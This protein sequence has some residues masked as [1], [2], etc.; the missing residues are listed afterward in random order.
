MSKLESKW[1]FK[2]ITTALGLATTVLLFQIAQYSI[3]FGNAGTFSQ[4]A[5]FILSTVGL[6][7]VFSFAIWFSALMAAPKLVR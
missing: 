2:T 3:P 4:F 6:Q 5:I 1:W 7:R